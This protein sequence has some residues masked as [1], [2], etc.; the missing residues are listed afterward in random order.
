MT[1]KTQAKAKG[2]SRKQAWILLVAGIVLVLGG[3]GMCSQHG[4]SWIIG[5]VVFL[6]GA[7][8]FLVGALRYDAWKRANETPKE[9]TELLAWKPALWM[10][11]G[12]TALAIGAFLGMLQQRPAWE[13]EL[14]IAS[15]IGAVVGLSG[16]EK[17]IKRLKRSSSG[18]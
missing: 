12:G 16:L 7:G 8:L 5:F 3:G 11:L 2:P 17:L 13:N 6:A 10:L 1:N 18:K 4:D 14:L 9:V 15:L